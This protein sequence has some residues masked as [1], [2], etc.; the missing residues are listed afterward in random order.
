MCTE[1]VL[2]G[3]DMEKRE[4]VLAR[5]RATCNC[6]QHKTERSARESKEARKQAHRQAARKKAKVPEGDLS[7][8]IELSHSRDKAFVT[9]CNATGLA[10]MDAGGTSDPYV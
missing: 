5:V 1:P 9:V 7:V 8:R 10:A 3:A 6:Q 4:A 2:C